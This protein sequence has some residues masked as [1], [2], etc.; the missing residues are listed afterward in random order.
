MQSKAREAFRG[1]RVVGAGGIEVSIAKAEFRTADG[2]EGERCGAERV[3][4]AELT[5]RTFNAKAQANHLFFYLLVVRKSFVVSHII[6]YV[7]G[8][9]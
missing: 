1:G 9:I 6:V 5:S 7:G 8:G 2:R 4:L 3:L